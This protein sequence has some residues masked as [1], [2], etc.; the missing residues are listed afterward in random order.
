M[1]ILEKRDCGQ[2]EIDQLSVLFI[3][4]IFFKNVFMYLSTSLCQ[5]LVVARRIVFYLEHVT[6]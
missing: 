5:A 3:Y 2:R 4:S 6:S 1:C